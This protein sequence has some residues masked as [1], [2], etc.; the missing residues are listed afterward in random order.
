M[1]DHTRQV[2]TASARTARLGSSS[3]AWSVS[4]SS[5]RYGYTCGKGSTEA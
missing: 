1:L 4:S 2:R 5:A 3:A